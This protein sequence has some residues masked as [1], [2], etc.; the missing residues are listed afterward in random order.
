MLA[1]LEQAQLEAQSALAASVTPDA[2]DA[3]KS[4]WIGGNGRLK[5]MMMALKDVPKD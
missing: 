4:A 5:S 1:D 3:W 2:L